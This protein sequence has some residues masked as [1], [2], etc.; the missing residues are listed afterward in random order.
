[1]RRLLLLRKVGNSAVIYKAVLVH[2]LVEGFIL[3]ARLL[4][5][6][7]DP[8]WREQVLLKML[9]RF[10]LTCSSLPS[11]PIQC[12]NRTRDLGDTTRTRM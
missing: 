4:G 6:G 7:K 8:Q 11:N 1:M 10:P 9:L 5:L 2:K 12:V 3:A